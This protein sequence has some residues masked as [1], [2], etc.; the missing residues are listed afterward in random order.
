MKSLLIAVDFDGC[1][2]YHRFPEIG[3]LCPGACHVLRKL[4][5]AGHRIILWTCRTNHDL[6]A[7]VR[8]VEYL[9]IRLHGWNSNRLED[10]YP[11]SP[12]VYADIYIDDKGLGCPLVHPEDGTPPYVDWPVVENILIE[13]GV[14]E[15]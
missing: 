15:R 14:I 5:N 10:E 4:E 13:R 6:R 12:K 11:G 3:D 7:A 2:V 1:I 8:I 9:G